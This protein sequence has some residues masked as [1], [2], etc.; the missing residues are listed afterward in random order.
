MCNEFLF[1]EIAWQEPCQEELGLISDTMRDITQEHC[2]ALQA[3]LVE[4]CWCKKLRG[5][6]PVAHKHRRM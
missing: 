6:Q 1:P 4:E 5:A 2:S 3:P